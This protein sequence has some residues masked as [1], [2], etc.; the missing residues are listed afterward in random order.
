MKWRGKM[1]EMGDLRIGRG[2]RRMT[3]CPFESGNARE[4]ET[5]IGIGTQ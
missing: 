2:W 5:G 4:G 1:R 3:W